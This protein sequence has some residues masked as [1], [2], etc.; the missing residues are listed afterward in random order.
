MNLANIEIIDITQPITNTIPHWPGDPL[1][2]IKSVAN[3]KT[4]GF[5]LNSLYIGEHT[6]THIGAPNHFVED[7]VDVASIK[8]EQLIVNG[9]KIDISG[10]ADDNPDY[11]LQKNDILDWEKANRPIEEKSVVLVQTNW[12]WLWSQPDKYFGFQNGELHFPGVSVKAAEYLVSKNINGIGIDTPGIDGGV[13]VVF[14]ANKELAA[15]GL[16][17]I[18]NLTNLDNL[19]SRFT[20]MIGA[21]PITGG[22]GSPCRI[23]A[24]QLKK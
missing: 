24:V 2:E 17:H 22:T 21:L 3:S 10:Q 20:L 12:S 11:L 1:T 15:N 8:P 16:Y 5:N 6:G 7:A 14:K 13:G 19:K 18:E 4:D 9:I 23:F